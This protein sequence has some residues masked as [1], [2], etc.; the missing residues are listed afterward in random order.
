M[1]KCSEIG[2]AL[3]EQ[4]IIGG[5][6]TLTVVAVVASLSG[7]FQG[8]MENVADGANAGVGNA[9]TANPNPMPAGQNN[10]P[11]NPPANYSP[12]GAGMSPVQ[13]TLSN[14]QTL[15]VQIPTSTAG[16]SSLVDT[17]GAN[18]A[19]SMINSQLVLMANELAQ[20]GDITAECL[21]SIGKPGACHGG[22]SGAS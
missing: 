7:N 13:F 6:L 14:G 3:S 15:E 20:A 8:L 12:I 10:N 5:A 16:L 22:C 4:V 2:Q 18:G 9:A 21:V 1:F 17:S 11:I 19:T